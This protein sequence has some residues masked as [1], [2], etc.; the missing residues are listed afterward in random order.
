MAAVEQ[1][2]GLLAQFA[3][4]SVDLDSE[5]ADARVE[6]GKD[7]PDRPPMRA[8]LPALQTPDERGIDPQ[9]FGELF[10]RHPSP[11]TQRSECVPED[12][13]VLFWGHLGV[14][15]HSGEHSRAAL[16]SARV[17]KV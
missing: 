14:A 17:F 10:L 7:A 5:V 8:A 6:R 1:T 13:L 11:L 9:P 15:A 2:A 12:E 3:L 4:S 16:P